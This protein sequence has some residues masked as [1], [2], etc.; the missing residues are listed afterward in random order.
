[1]LEIAYANRAPVYLQIPEGHSG[2]QA[3]EFEAVLRA[4]RG[5]FGLQRSGIEFRYWSRGAAVRVRVSLIV[6]LS[7]SSF[8]SGKKLLVGDYTVQRGESITV[9]HLSQFGLQPVNMKIITANPPG[10]SPPE[11]FNESSSTTVEKISQNRAEYR[12]FLRNN[13][14]LVVHATVVSVFDRNGSFSTPVPDQ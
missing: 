7:A 14:E 12:L 8:G 4:K 10:A 13:S 11:I 9:S 1:M 2:N 5:A 6:D 3:D